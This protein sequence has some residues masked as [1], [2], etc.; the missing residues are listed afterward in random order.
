MKS[1]SQS[2]Q[3]ELQSRYPCSTTWHNDAP[4]GTANLAR[5]KL[6]TNNNISHPTDQMRTDETKTQISIS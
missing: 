6:E 1:C 2:E 3:I 5:S 4:I